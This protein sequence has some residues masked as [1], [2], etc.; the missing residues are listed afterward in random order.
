MYTHLV[1]VLEVAIP[2]PSHANVL[3]VAME[4]VK[5]AVIE[6]KPRRKRL[7][8]PEQEY[9]RICRSEIYEECWLTASNRAVDT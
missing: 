5:I 6:K 2:V 3:T 8:H 7:R 1:P 9:K 4:S